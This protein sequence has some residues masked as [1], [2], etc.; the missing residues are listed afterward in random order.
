MY[1][2]SFFQIFFRIKNFQNKNIEAQTENY[3]P[4]SHTTTHAHINIHIHSHI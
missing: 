2:V 4:D 1:I 3:T